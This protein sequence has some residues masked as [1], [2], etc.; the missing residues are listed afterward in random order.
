MKSDNVICRRRWIGFA[1]AS[2][3]N[4]RVIGLTGEE[5]GRLIVY[6]DQRHF[7]N[8]CNLLSCLSNQDVNA[9]LGKYPVAVETVHCLEK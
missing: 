3:E 9:A 5:C 1:S 6:V 8:L 7:K 4:A 2:Q